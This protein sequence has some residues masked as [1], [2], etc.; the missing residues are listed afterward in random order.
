MK[1]RPWFKHYDK[2]VPDTLAPY[3]ELTLIAVLSDSASQRP[4][5]PALLFQGNTISYGELDRQSTMFAGALTDLGIKPGDRVA[6]LLP[7]SPQLMISMFGAWK[8]G[9]IIVPLNPLYTERELEHALCESGAGTVIVLTPFYNKVKA[10][11]PHTPVRNVIATNIKE[12]LQPIKKFLF[13][14]AK[15]K[16]EGH[17]IDLQQG[18][19]WLSN[20]L[21]PDNHAHKSFYPVKHTDP[22]ILL[23]SG[24]TTG[25]PKAALGTHHS[26]F[27][28]GMQLRTWLRNVLKDWDDVI[29]LNM[30]LF[31][32]YGLVGVMAT[33][34]V[35]HN[36]FAVIPN[37]R[38]LSDLLKTIQK[39]RPAFLPGVPTIFNALL[40]HPKVTSGQIDLTCIKL[41]ISGASS[42]LAETKQRFETVTGGRIIEAYALTESMLGAT[43]SPVLGVYKPGSIGIPLPD[44][45]V[46]IVDIETGEDKL[47]YGEIGEILLRAPQVMQG[48]WKKPEETTQILRDGWLF[49]GDIGYQDED[50]YVFIVDRK[51]DLIKPGGFQVWPR[52][53]EEVIATHPSVAEVCVGGI[54]DLHS[55]E[56]V[57]AWVVLYAGQA[58]SEAE[59]RD[60]CRKRLAAYKIPKVIEFRESLPKS[61]VGK[62]LRRELLAKEK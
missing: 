2:G 15:E 19:L 34:L 26:L 32:A 57:K 60:Y 5:H 31:H 40:D 43:V 41:C 50:G 29:L 22:A 21:S 24:G 62:I 36:T 16:K 20:L 9:G 49:T 14:L 8:A 10:V 52:D 6:L 3:P 53:V 4:G 35:G 46:R 45:E 13:T 59:L 39:V 12:Y 7:N 11:Q 18:D 47:T 58:L 1:N 30:P 37:P 33:G 51:K 28:A 25:T 17:H 55:V 23:F 48:Y 61:N 38:D 42:L 56:A 44:V 54:P 27:M